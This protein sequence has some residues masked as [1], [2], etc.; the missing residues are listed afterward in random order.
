M[1]SDLCNDMCSFLG[2]PEFLWKCIFDVAKILIVGLILGVFAAKYQKRKEVEHK[3]KG[4]LLKLRL[5]TLKKLNALNFLIYKRIQPPIE[6]E[7]VY[8]SIINGMPFI[9]REC[10]YCSFFASKSDFDAYYKSIGEFVQQEQIHFNYKVSSILTEYLSYLAEI[11]TFLYAFADTCPERKDTAAQVLGIVL[12]NDFNRFYAKID[13]TIAHEFRHITIEYKSHYIKSIYNR[14]RLW[15]INKLEQQVGGN[16]IYKTLYYK[17]V[18][19]LY[20]HSELIRHPVEIILIFM[21]VYYMDKYTRDEFDDMSDNK[22]RTEL[23]NAF[24]QKFIANYHA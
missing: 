14:C 15:L 16:K 11:Q 17:C 13:Q 7:S 2:L 6:Q 8:M 19:R 21:Y 24:H 4:E 3:I 5:E 12:Q 9:V 18:Y 10:E 23:V 22:E 20:G 1:V